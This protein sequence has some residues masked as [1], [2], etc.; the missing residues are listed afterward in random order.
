[1]SGET[2]T[3]KECMERYSETPYASYITDT[4]ICVLNPG[5]SAC[6]EDSGDYYFKLIDF[7]LLSL[8]V[9]SFI[10]NI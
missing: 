6:N 3:Q 9:P 2:I 8:S 7:I 1:M 4:V 5:R 10:R